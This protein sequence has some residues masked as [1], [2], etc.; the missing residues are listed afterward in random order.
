M[1]EIRFLRT[2]SLSDRVGILEPISIV[3]D[4]NEIPVAAI[5][6]TDKGNPYTIPADRTG[7]K[8]ITR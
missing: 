3:Q 7:K 4:D 5:T 1:N 2:V 8:F 6:L